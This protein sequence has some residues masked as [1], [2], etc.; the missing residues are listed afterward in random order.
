MT[1]QATGRHQGLLQIEPLSQLIG[2][3]SGARH[4]LTRDIGDITI[5]RQLH[6]GQADAVGGNGVTQLDVA[7][8]QLAAAYPDGHIL[9]LGLQ[10]NQGA[11]RFN[12]SSKHGYSSCRCG[13]SVRRRSSP[14]WQTSRSENWGA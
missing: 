14:I 13:W 6:H 7:Q 8:I 2:G 3:K 4:G 1:A 5:P 10:G 9:P 12:D 11:N